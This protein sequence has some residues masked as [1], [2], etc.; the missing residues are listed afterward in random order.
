MSAFATN[1]TKLENHCSTVYSL[2]FLFK[3]CS[4]L[5]YKLNIDGVMVSKHDPS[6]TVTQRNTV[7]GE[8]N[9]IE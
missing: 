8:A 9:S 1:P 2:S 6:H 7:C 3:H 5:Q 4:E